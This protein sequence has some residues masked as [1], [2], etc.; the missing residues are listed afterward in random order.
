MIL[1][2]NKMK[3][4]GIRP[5]AFLSVGCACLLGLICFWQ[6]SVAEAQ[7][8]QEEPTLQEIAL[9][10]TDENLKE[11]LKRLQ[12]LERLL[13]VA[14]EAGFTEAE[15]ANITVDRDGD[16]VNVLEFV[17]QERAW[18]IQSSEKVE[19]GKKER[20]LTVQDITNELRQQE[21]KQLDDL[22]ESIIFSGEK[23]E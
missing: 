13:E 23:E 20:Y 12:E 11:R 16:K 22:R 19:I 7:A 17:K 3:H 18:F 4:P 10:I 15:V 8:Q 14:R 9:T 1:T 21:P 2:A 6:I 5:A